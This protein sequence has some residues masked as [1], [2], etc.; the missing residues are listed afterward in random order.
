MPLGPYGGIKIDG[1]QLSSDPATYKPLEWEKRWSYHPTL[2]GGGVVQDFGVSMKD[3][4]LVLQSGPNNP[5]SDDVV[6]ALHTRWRQAAATFPF[7]D[8][9]GNAFTVR[10]LAFK[11]WPLKSGLD[12]NNQPLHLYLWEGQL[13]VVA[14]SQLLGSPYSG[15]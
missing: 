1:I 11:P 8:W 4:T 5:I 9:L 14:I 7:V 15:T 2:G 10:I 13:Q 3:D 12:E 6:V